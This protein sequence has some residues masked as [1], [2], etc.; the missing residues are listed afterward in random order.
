MTY[1]LN[2]NSQS[3][4]IYLDS[5]N[6]NQR[7]PHFRYQLNTAVSCAPSMRMLI[8]VQ[9]ATLPNVIQNVNAYND[10]ISYISNG[11]EY[12]LVFPHGIYSAWTWK[13]YFNANTQ[14]TL[15]C[16]Y[17][18]FVFTFITEYSFQII[19]TETHPTTCG[20]LIGVSKNND[21][22]FIYPQVADVPYFTLVM[23]STVNFVPSPY[24]FL[25]I[26]D[27]QLS[28]INSY[29]NINDCFIRIPVNCPYGELIQ[30]RPVEVTRF[31]IS[32]NSLNFIELKLED[33]QNNPLE[34]PSGV[35]LQVV[36]NIEF[37]YP[38]E[39]VAFDK[40]TMEHSRRLAAMPEPDVKKDEGL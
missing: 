2:T 21:N 27:L 18:N 7:R 4:T 25:K 13:D 22:D 30:Y 1:V 40:G 16:L 6:C 19:N 5:T 37:I 23:P 11:G 10:T 35:E 8:S 17:S 38:Q 15:Q 32:Q 31:I 39:T 3:E 12:T 29:G 33:S 36:L 24:I 34:I 14:G 20:G 9:Q 28:N 26:A